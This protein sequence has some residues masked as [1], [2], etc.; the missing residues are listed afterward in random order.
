M[1][2]SPPKTEVSGRMSEADWDPFLRIA[3]GPAAIHA[4]STG[5]THGSTRP[6][7]INVVTKTLA[8]REPSTHGVTADINQ[9]YR[10]FRV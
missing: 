3:L 9:G 10:D 4:A 5:R 7:C 6:H 1:S 8:K 2:A